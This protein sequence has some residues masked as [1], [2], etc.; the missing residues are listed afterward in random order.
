MHTDTRN[1]DEDIDHNEYDN[2]KTIFWS[3]SS[4]TNHSTCRTLDNWILDDIPK[5]LR[6]QGHVLQGPTLGRDE[7]ACDFKVRRAKMEEAQEEELVEVIP[8]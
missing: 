6:R 2:N 8:H 1:Y 5:Q 3:K 7:E 4:S